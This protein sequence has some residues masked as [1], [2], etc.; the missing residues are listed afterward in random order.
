MKAVTFKHQN[1]VFAENQPEYTPLPALKFDTSQG[2]VVTCW[3]LSFKERLKIL[4]FGKIW[5]SVLTFNQ[6][7]SP[8]YMSVD[9]KDIYSHPDDINFLYRLKKKF[10]I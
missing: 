7:L 8:I 5:L 6:P 3:K 2:E 4:M 10:K 9:R 1:I